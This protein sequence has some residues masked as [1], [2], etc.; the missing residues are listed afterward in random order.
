MASGAFVLL[1]GRKT[2]LIGHAGGDGSRL[3]QPRMFC[4]N[5]ERS[6]HPILAPKPG[7][8][9]PDQRAPGPGQSS[10]SARQAP[11]ID[12]F[13]Q[14]GGFDMDSDRVRL[15][16]LVDDNPVAGGVWSCIFTPDG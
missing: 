2:R 11:C 12:L 13:Q 6:N 7:E 8:K 4:L 9:L 3:A 5:R 1:L 16:E 15:L 10:P 14:Q